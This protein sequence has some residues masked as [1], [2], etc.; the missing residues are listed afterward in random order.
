MNATLKAATIRHNQP[1]DGIEIH[2]SGKPEVQILDLLKADGFR[3]SRFS[4][5][6]YKRV[7]IS[8]IETAAKF[9]TVPA[10]LNPA[11]IAEQNEIA[12]VSGYIQ[13]QEEAQYERFEYSL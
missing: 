1:K 7:S 2:F 5:C 13:A 8:A 11:A 6:W 4:K 3:W 12:S 10:S 9:G